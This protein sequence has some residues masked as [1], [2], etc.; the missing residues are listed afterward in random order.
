M[1]L[2]SKWKCIHA[3]YVVNGLPTNMNVMDITYDKCIITWHYMQLKLIAL[4]SVNRFQR[5]LIVRLLLQS[6]QKLKTI[7]MNLGL[8]GIVM[9]HAEEI[10]VLG[11]PPNN[12][13]RTSNGSK[14]P[15]S[16]QRL[17]VRQLLANTQSINVVVA[18]TLRKWR[19]A[20]NH[21]FILDSATISKNYINQTES[22][23]D[24]QKR[25]KREELGPLHV[26]VWNQW[27][28]SMLNYP[29]VKDHPSTFRFGGVHP[30]DQWLEGHRHCTGRK[31]GE[32]SEMLQSTIQESHR[33]CSPRQCC[34]EGVGRCGAGVG[35]GELLAIEGQCPQ[36]RFREALA[37]D[38]GQ[39]MIS[40]FTDI[41]PNFQKE[42][43]GDSFFQTRKNFQAFGEGFF[44]RL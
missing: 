22:G 13:G 8:E 12:S 16:H 27:L 32:D 31:S 33:S 24:Q 29:P 42:N 39:I 38:L 6:G 25:V 5:R 41:V 10:L 30:E 2:T 36:R 1:W 14:K 7:A 44:K 40:Q 34:V 35:Q 17:M 28:K 19:V 37:G 43:E 11:A 15:E 23:D 18:A 21:Q 9:Q 20:H 3:H 26:H 4:Q